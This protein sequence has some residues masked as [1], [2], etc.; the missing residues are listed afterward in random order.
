MKIT[1]AQRLDASRLTNLTIRSKA[2]WNYSPQQ[3]E[4]WREDLTITESDLLQQQIFMLVDCKELKGFY[5]YN[6]ISDSDVKLNYLFIDPQFIG[7]GLGRILMNDFL[8]RI[9]Q[10]QYERVVLDADPNAEL[11]YKKLGFQVIGQ[12]KSSIKDRYLPIMELKREQVT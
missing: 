9:G 2:Y 8:Q 7:K 4:E 1:K 12:L 10:T 6:H 5:A 11:F 3:I